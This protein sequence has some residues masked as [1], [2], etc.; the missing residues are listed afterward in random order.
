MRFGTLVVAT[1][2]AVAGTSAEAVTIITQSFNSTFSRYGSR[3]AIQIGNLNLS[4]QVITSAVIS[5]AAGTSYSRDF[6]SF[7]PSD[8]GALSY[9]GSAGFEIFGS[10]LPAPASVSVSFSGISPCAS[11]RCAASGATSGEYIVPEADL[12]AFAGSG[13]LLI[14]AAGGFAGDV[15]A[16]GGIYLRAPETS[17]YASGTITYSIADVTPVPE[18]ATWAMMIVG[19]GAVGWGLRRRRARSASFRLLE[20]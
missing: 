20:R 5:Y 18:P 13:L 16:R 10:S 6:F 2:M 7:D 14:K 4:N 11:G 17:T 8:S 15:S 3:G 1:I 19:F 12:A 9:S